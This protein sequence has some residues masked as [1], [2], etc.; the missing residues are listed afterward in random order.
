MPRYGY[1]MTAA[2]VD[3]YLRRLHPAHAG[4]CQGAYPVPPVA[5][6]PA[7]EPGGWQVRLC[8]RLPWPPS[9]NNL[10]ATFQGR[11]LLSTRGRRYHKDVAGIVLEQQ[12]Q[13]SQ[14]EFPLQGR[15]LLEVDVHAPDKRKRDIA[16]IEKVVTDSLVTAGVMLDDSQIDEVRLRRQAVQRGGCVVVCVSERSEG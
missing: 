9:S 16:N 10:Y 7:T 14:G 3:A 8:L 4:L 1:H 11:R 13:H 6:A 2:D 12:G 5:P 15:L